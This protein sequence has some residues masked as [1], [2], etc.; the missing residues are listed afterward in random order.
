MRIGLQTWG[1]EGDVAPFLA[2]AAGLVAAG[3]RATLVV[4]DNAGRSYRPQAEAA[5]FGLVEVPVPGLDAHRIE[6]VW[7]EILAL[8]NPLRQ[9]E[10]ILRHGY[11]PVAPAMLRAAQELVSRSDAVLGHFFAYP[12]RIAAEQAGVPAATLQVVHNC[13]PTRDW[14]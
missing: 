3:H 1:S 7:R 8:R 14:P 4:T 10:V 9:L 11:D 5:G 6:R 12:L 13:I 2:L